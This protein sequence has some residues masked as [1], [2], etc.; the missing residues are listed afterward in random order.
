MPNKFH[1]KLS[2]CGQYMTILPTQHTQMNISCNQ[3]SKCDA[4]LVFMYKV[5]QVEMLLNYSCD[6]SQDYKC[7]E[8]R[9]SFSLMTSYHIHCKVKVR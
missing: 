6:V 1:L 2:W 4:L 7:W 9:S 3:V 8:Q 5:L